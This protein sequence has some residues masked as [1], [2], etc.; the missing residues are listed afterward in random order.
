MAGARCDGDGDGEGLGSAA[1]A[2]FAD[3]VGEDG[4]GERVTCGATVECVGCG[5]GEGRAAALVLA[6]GGMVAVQVTIPQSAARAR[7]RG[8]A[9]CGPEISAL[10]AAAMTQA[11]VAIAA[12]GRRRTSEPSHRRPVTM[13]PP[14]AHQA[15]PM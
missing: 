11:P 4:V 9:W 8:P 7:R 13:R 2:G 3:G 10:P 15:T 5:L 6:R 14:P 1:A 12:Y